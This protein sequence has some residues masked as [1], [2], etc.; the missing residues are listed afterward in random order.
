MDFMHDQLNDGRTFRLFNVLDDFNREGLGI[1][2]NLSCRRPDL[3]G[4]WSRSCNGEGNPR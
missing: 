2:V 1:E 3:F 4:R